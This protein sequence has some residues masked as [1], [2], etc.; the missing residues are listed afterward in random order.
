MCYTHTHIPAMSSYI[1]WCEQILEKLTKQKLQVPPPQGAIRMALLKLIHLKNSWWCGG[2]SS[3]PLRDSLLF[4]ILVFCF[5]SHI[6]E[7]AVCKRESGVF[8]SWQSESSRNSSCLAKKMVVLV[9][10]PDAKSI[11]KNFKRQS[12]EK[13]FGISTGTLIKKKG[14]GAHLISTTE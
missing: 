1:W 9:G 5:S 14:G 8:S 3:A 10:N 13:A 2:S 6:R 4:Y 11:C 7:E 12:R